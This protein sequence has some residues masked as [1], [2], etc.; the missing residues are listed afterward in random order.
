[1]TTEA[2]PVCRD[3]HHRICGGHGCECTCHPGTVAER[4]AKADAAVADWLTEL[5]EVV[6]STGRHEGHTLRQVGRCVYCSCGCRYQ[7]TL[8]KK[9]R[10]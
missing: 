1:M 4:A 8:P 10:P 5:N 6:G 3:G 9:A 7:G 2:S